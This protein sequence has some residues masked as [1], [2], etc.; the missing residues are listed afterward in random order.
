M[1]FN[2]LYYPFDYHSAYRP[3]V[4]RVSSS[5]YLPP[6]VFSA[7]ALG[8]AVRLATSTEVDLYGISSTDVVVQHTAATFY[9]NELVALPLSATSSDLSGTSRYPGTYRI[10]RV[11][12]DT[13]MV[14]AAT[15]VGID[16]FGGSVCKVKGNYTVF[17]VVYGPNIPQP[18]E[19]S[20][21]PVLSDVFG[22]IAYIFEL[23]CRDVI[24]RHFKDI[25]NLVTANT[26]AITDAEGYISMKYSVRMYAGYDVVS[27]LG[28]VTFT[29]FDGPDEVGFEI[30]NQVAVNAI[31]PYHHTERDGTVDLDWADSFSD[32]YVMNTIGV[33]GPVTT[34]RFLSYMDRD[35]TKIRSGDAFF[36]AFLWQGTPLSRGKIRIRYVNAAGSNISTVDIGNPGNNNLGAT[37][38][39]ANVG[40]AAHTAPAGAVKFLVWLINGSTDARMSEIWTFNIEACKGINKRWYYLNKL[41][42]VDAFTFQGDETRQMSV[43]RDILSKPNMAI[44]DVL[45]FSGQTFTND[46]QSRVWRTTPQRKYTIS[47]GFL[48]PKELRVVAE[49]MFES[50]NI[51]TEIRDGWWTNIIPIT[52]E[53]AGDRDSG[54]AERFVIQYQLGV[55]N[56]TQ[57]T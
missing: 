49:E 36:L 23:D 54:R 17:A 34:K 40:L 9:N 1:S 48:L 39:I 11:L 6:S 31:H 27:P 53:T 3:I 26:T 29:R 38:Y 33:G 43:R 50:A 46:Y 24:A 22:S 57:R 12:S 21:K 28:V 8:V 56:A 13:L 20:L 16:T 44:P 32:D 52:T 18:V 51:F 5:E 2:P 47:S 42:G 55:D 19:F 4:Y 14:V 25:K 37:S 15:Y 45:A 7:S 30:F 10:T 35:L 41:G